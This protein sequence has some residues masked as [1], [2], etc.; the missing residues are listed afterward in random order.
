MSLQKQIVL[1]QKNPH[2]P[3]GRWLEI[4]RGRGGVFKSTFLE[5]M[6]EWIK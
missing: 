6:Y 1:F 3:H 5:A 4:P 2:P